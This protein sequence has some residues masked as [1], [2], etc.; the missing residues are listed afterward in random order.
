M[1]MKVILCNHDV[2]KK[3]FDFKL[4]LLKANF[5][6]IFVSIALATLGPTLIGQRQV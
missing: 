4:L 2:R 3:S 5:L 1:S 6:S